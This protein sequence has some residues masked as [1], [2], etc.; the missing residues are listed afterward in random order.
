MVLSAGRVRSKREPW[1]GEV[2]KAA[3]NGARTSSAVARTRQ[4]GSAKAANSHFMLT[5]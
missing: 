4:A 2:G 1:L 3:E 5:P